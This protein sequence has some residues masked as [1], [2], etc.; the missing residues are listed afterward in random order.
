MSKQ[1]PLPLPEVLEP[2]I[3][4]NLEYHVLICCG[5]GCQ[6]AQS[7]SAI[8]RHLRDKHQ[9]SLELRKELDQ[10]LEQ[11]QWP[12]DAQSILLPPDGLAP[13]P[14][15]LVYDGFLCRDCIYKTRNRK[16]CREH[17]NIEHCK[18]RAKDEEVFIAVRLQTWFGQK[19][20]RYWVVD[21]SKEVL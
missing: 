11:W 16:A 2:W 20:E 1:L 3:K 7:P 12:Y 18:K 17:A 19:R 9:A 6:Q 14:D 10:Y 13:Q 15:L 8:S 5:N 21:E 4:V